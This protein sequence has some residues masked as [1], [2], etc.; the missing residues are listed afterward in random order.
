[1]PTLTVELSGNQ[2][3]F[4]PGDPVDG[5]AGWE[6]GGDAPPWVEVRLYWA[7]SGKGTPDVVVA[8]AQK[9]EAPAAVDAQVFRFVAP[10]GPF[11]YEGRL[12]E[13]GWGIEVVAHKTK[14]V[15]QL[16]L[17]LSN[18]GDAVRLP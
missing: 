10:D 18:S 15:A 13:I 5:L 8:Q 2:T 14:E 1:M 3:A 9:F 12:I 17:T 6:F 4:R 16:D 7:T 11:S